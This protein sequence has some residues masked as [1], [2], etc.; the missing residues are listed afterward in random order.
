MRSMLLR[1]PHRYGGKGNSIWCILH[2]GK[3]EI[4]K[5]NKIEHHMFLYITIN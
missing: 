1:F 2:K 3:R 4:S 5:W